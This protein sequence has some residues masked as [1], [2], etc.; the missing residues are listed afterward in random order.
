MRLARHATTGKLLDA[1][2]PSGYGEAMKESKRATIYFAADLHRALRLKAASAQASISALVNDVVRVALS[3]DAED[4]AAADQRRAE[5]RVSSFVRG[6][7]QR[8]R[9]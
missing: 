3:K 5:L 9:I 8:G 1:Q 4:L 2:T 7:R 6:L